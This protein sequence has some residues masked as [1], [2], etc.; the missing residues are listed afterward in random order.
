MEKMKEQLTLPVRS[1]GNDLFDF[2]GVFLKSDQPLVT[3]TA[4]PP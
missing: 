1:G 3:P 2:L 4:S